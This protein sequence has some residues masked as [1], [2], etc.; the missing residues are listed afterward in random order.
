MNEQHRASKAAQKECMELY[1]LLLLHSKPHVESALLVGIQVCGIGA[2]RACLS[3]QMHDED[4]C[5]L[6]DTNI[7]D[8]QMITRK[9]TR[10]PNVIAV[11]SQGRDQLDVFVP[12]IQMRG[13]VRMMDSRGTVKAP[14][15]GSEG[16]E[17]GRMDE[18]GV[19]RSVNQ[20]SL[21]RQCITHTHTHT[22][23]YTQA[24]THTPPTAVFLTELPPTP[25]HL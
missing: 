20:L 6:T 5:K 8:V 2:G 1:L 3:Y 23:S 9:H 4:A 25:F 13:K 7:P 21:S 12:S 24:H 18:V 22:H 14:L 10:S 17:E 19:V 16:E 15:T 11:L